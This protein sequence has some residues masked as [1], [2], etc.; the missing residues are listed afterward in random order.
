MEE[1]KVIA[2]SPVL[3][4]MDLK[5]TVWRTIW[6]PPFPN[7]EVEEDPNVYKMGVSIFYSTST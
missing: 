3:L 7:A 4:E 1:S 2:L 5:G 6:V